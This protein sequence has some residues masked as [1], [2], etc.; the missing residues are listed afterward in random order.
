MEQGLPQPQQAPGMGQGLAQQ[1]ATEQGQAAVQEIVALLMQGVDPEELVKQGI[2]VELI[3]EAIQIIMAQEQQ[4][5]V[6]NQPAQTQA[7]SA[8]LGAI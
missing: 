6:A 2:P 4:E 8:M 7:G 3:Q 1:G 5:Q